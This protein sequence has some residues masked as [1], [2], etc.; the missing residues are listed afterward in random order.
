MI[1][2][3][4]SD[5]SGEGIC[6]VDIWGKAFQV[7]ETIGKGLRQDLAWTAQGLW[8]GHCGQRGGRQGKSIRRWRQR[9]QGVNYILLTE[10]G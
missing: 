4:R 2:E 10:M 8:L 9:G 6:H 7:E 3:Q 1:S 5:E